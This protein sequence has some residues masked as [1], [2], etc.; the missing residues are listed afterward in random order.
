MVD[1]ELARY[2]TRLCHSRVLRIKVPAHSD[3]GRRL[4]FATWLLECL[5]VRSGASEGLESDLGLAALLA[6]T[7]GRWSDRSLHV[8]DVAISLGIPPDVVP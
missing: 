5:G 4:E 6:T 8:H 7:F 1:G 2:L 3:P